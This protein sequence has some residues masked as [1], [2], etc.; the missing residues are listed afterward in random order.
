MAMSRLFE[1]SESWLQG[2]PN[3]LALT[4][5]CGGETR[6]GQP[7]G[8]KALMLAVL[9]D[10]IRSFLS[11]ISQ[12]RLEAEFWILS[13]RRRSPF[14]FNVVCETLGLDPTAAREAILRFRNVERSGRRPLRRSR[15]NV[16]RRGRLLT[17]KAH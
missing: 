9:E 12:I 2:L 13:K 5:I 4:P 8:V 3:L 6:I 15:P 10:G 7:T 17:A 1:D 11:P 16:H 14:S